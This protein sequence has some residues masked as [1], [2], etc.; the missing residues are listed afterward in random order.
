MKN[1]KLSF[2]FPVILLSACAGT[3]VKQEESTAAPAATVMKQAQAKVASGLS[4]AELKTQLVGKTMFGTINGKGWTTALKSDGTAIMHYD[5]KF[6]TNAVYTLRSN[7]YCRTRENNGNNSCWTVS[8]AAK[9]YSLKAISGRS[10]RSFGFRVK[11]TIAGA[12]ATPNLNDA[13]LKSPPCW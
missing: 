13:Q 5:G 8:K 9:G 4:N 10:T 1:M 3:E 6:D 2:L 7:M 11:P 12:K